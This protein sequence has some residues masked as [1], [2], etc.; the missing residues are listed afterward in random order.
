[1]ESN[2]LATLACATPEEL[3]REVF[4][5]KE[6][7]RRSLASLSVEEKFRLFLELQRTVAAAR[8]AAGRRGPDP[9]PVG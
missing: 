5:Q 8:R 4:A 3:A 2:P 1:M 6:R 7:R 9:W